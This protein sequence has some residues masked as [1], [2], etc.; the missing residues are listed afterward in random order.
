MTFDIN[1]FAQ[2][3]SPDV[4]VRRLAEVLA[5]QKQH[6]RRALAEA[7]AEQKQRVQRTLAEAMQA[8][9]AP[10]FLTEPAQVTRELAEAITSEQSPSHRIERLMDG[11]ERVPPPFVRGRGDRWQDEERLVRRVADEVARRLLPHQPEPPASAS[12]AALP[13]AL[14]APAAPAAPDSAS[15]PAAGLPDAVAVPAGAPETPAQRRE[16]LRAR[17]NYWKG[18][19]VRDWTERVAGEEG[20]TVGRIRQILGRAKPEEPTGGRKKPRQAATFC[21]GLMAPSGRTR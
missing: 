5:E 9:A 20:V 16:R 2:A 4:G 12:P 1:K 7:L 6:G 17:A 3:M 11:V 8:A 18:Q 15:A 13:G 19:G 10:H 14:P 21:S